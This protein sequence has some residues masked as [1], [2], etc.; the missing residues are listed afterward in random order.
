MAL[1][2]TLTS[3]QSNVHVAKSRTQDIDITRLAFLFQ[4][5]TTMDL[6]SRIENPTSY[7]INEVVRLR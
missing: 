5:R 7:K 1:T 3:K 6:F 4:T 2:L